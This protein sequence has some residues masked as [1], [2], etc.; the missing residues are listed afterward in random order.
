MVRARRLPGEPSPA[1]PTQE[2]FLAFGRV[3]SGVARAGQAVYVLPATYDPAA[4]AGEGGPA[5]LPATMGTLYLMM[6]R[7]LER[8]QASRVPGWSGEGGRG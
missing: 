3:F 5:A 7:G 6:G 2:H 4:A 1:N 8:L